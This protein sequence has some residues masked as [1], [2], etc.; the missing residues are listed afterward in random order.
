MNLCKTTYIKD[1]N[2][3]I[4]GIK[5][6][7]LAQKYGTPLYVMDVARIRTIV[8]AYSDTLTNKYGNAHKIGRAHV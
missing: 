8:R 1:N 7:E 3:F 5:A 2:L 6:D 4:G